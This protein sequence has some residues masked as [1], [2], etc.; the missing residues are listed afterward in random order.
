VDLANIDEAIKPG[1]H[2]EVEIAAEIYP[3]RLLVPQDAILTRS[4]R[5][6]V[7]VVENGRAKWKYINVGLENEEFAE[8]LPGD[9]PGG[10]IKPDDQVLVEGHF[11]IAHD[12]PVRIIQ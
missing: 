11:T 8:V 1:M 3:D 7:F 10:G 4:G 6:L 12:A 5:K 2:A 9:T